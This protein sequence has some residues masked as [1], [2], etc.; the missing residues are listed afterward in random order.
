[1]SLGGNFSSGYTEKLNESVI[2]FGIEKNE[3][4]GYNNACV[5]TYI[6]GSQI[7]PVANYPSMI[8]AANVCPISSP[9]VFAS[10]P[11]IAMLSSQLTQQK[12]SVVCM[13]FDAT[14]RFSKY[15]RYQ[16]P[17]PCQPVPQSANMA[18]ISLPN[19]IPCKINPYT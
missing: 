9:Q 8:L 10:Y 15:N 6:S 16:I 2:Q 18:G 7:T 13:N 5:E 3:N 1:M 17:V 11:K 4:R 12:S 19:A 14:Q